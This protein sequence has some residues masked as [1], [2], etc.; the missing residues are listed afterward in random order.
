MRYCV[1]PC[2]L[3]CYGSCEVLD[4][5]SSSAHGLSHCHSFRRHSFRLTFTLGASSL[6]VAEPLEHILYLRHVPNV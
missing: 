5:S 6:D 4:N 1:V 3:P 2:A